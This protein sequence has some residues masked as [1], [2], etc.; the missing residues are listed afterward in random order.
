MSRDVIYRVRAKHELWELKINWVQAFVLFTL[1]HK[2]GS[3][4]ELE[5]SLRPT[6]I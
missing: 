2:S 4:L 1:N 3:D 5:L 6:L